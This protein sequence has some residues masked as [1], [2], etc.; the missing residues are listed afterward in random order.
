MRRQS[1]IHLAL[2]ELLLARRVT[3]SLATPFHF[4]SRSQSP[5]ALQSFVDGSTTTHIRAHFQLFGGEFTSKGEDGRAESRQTR[6]PANPLFVGL[7]TV[8]AASFSSSDT[9]IDAIR[10]QATSRVTA[11]LEQCL[12]SSIRQLVCPRKPPTLGARGSSFAFRSADVDTGK[13]RSSLV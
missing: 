11:F 1:L 12:T 6:P 2:V 8:H 9:S 4:T 13:R 10:A 3:L 7:L 5:V